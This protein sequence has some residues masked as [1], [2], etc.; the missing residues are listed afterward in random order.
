MDQFERSCRRCNYPDSM[1]GC[2]EYVD[3]LG[4]AVCAECCSALLDMLQPQP[5]EQSEPDEHKPRS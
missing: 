3:D 5:N 1:V 2:V 4:M